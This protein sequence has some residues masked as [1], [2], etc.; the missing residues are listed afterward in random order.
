MPDHK[1]SPPPADTDPAPTGTR[2]PSLARR[3]PP[4]LRLA[5]V[6][7]LVTAPD[8][9]RAARSLIE[10]AHQHA[11]DLDLLWGAVHPPVLPQR[12]R[13]PAQIP[14]PTVSQTCLAVPTAGRTAMLFLSAPDARFG[15]PA[16]QRAELAETLRLALR[17][18][19]NAA[20]TPLVLAQTL[21]ETHHDWAEAACRDAGLTWVGRLHFMRLPWPVRFPQDDPAAQPW[22]DDITIAPIANPLDFTPAG[23]GTALARALE[24]TYTDTLDC[25]ELCGLRHTR[26]VITSHMAT[27]EFDPK[28]WWIIRRSGAPEGCCLLNHCPA[29]RAVELVY[30]GISPNL[31]GRRLARRLLI[32]ALTRVDA[33]DAREITCAVDTRNTP[34]VKLYH[35]MG[36]RNFGSRTGFVMPLASAQVE[37]KISTIVPPRGQS[38]SFGTSG[39]QE[40]VASAKRL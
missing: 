27:G 3:I 19:P 8:R 11:I 20:K 37:P 23:D 34:A 35:S 13:L 17:E 24:A 16:V 25:P 36:F 28:R 31:R 6:E 39:G 30:L 22:P 9:A 15:P 7:R 5:A 38:G 1:S 29:N 2:H 12:P 18:L 32:H 21:L 40:N 4:E 26:D 14:A 10:S 33:P